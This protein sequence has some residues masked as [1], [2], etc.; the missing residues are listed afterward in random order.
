M[1]KNV[2]KW[3]R[4]LQAD[5]Q[6]MVS[7]DVETS[8]PNP[9]NYDLLSIG[10]CTIKEPGRTFYVELQP[11]TGNTTQEAQQVHG[12]E[13]ARLSVVG[14]APDVAMAMFADWL[15][16]N[17]GGETKPLFVG[18]NAPFDWMFVCDYFHRYHGR[19]PFGHS[20]L[21]IKSFYMAYA[22]VPWSGTSMD[23]LS[24]IELQHNALQD[25]CDQAKLFEK[26]ISDEI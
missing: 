14:T 9:A 22:K 4:W 18:F 11:V 15:L 2:K 16:A 6:R 10:A 23:K 24:A 19:N 25:A 17:I 26:I 5:L 13:M 7:V 3:P 8:G 12:L 20:A 1:K 21:D